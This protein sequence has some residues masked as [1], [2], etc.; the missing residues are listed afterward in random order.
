MKTKLM[1]TKKSLPTIG[2]GAYEQKILTR[3]MHQHR[4]K[5]K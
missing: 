3:M 5:R 4:P 1:S 2:E